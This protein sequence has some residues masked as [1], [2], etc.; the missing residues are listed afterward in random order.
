MA[1]L[2]DISEKNLSEDD[3]HRLLDMIEKA[4]KEGR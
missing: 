3:Y 2:L 1:A 4:K